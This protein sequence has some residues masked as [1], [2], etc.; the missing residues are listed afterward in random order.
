[1][2]VSVVAL[3][4]FLGGCAPAT[5]TAWPSV[6][7]VVC[8][9]TKTS[10]GAD[11]D[12]GGFALELVS[13]PSLA[14]RERL[15]R[16]QN[17]CRR[18]RPDTSRGEIDRVEC[19]DP[20][21]DVRTIVRLLRHSPARVVIEVSDHDEGIFERVKLTREIVISPKAEARLEL[22]SGCTP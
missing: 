19:V 21:A 17:G 2:V 9:I 22:R 12:D 13:E 5:A 14:K 8:G 6:D 10:A 16:L 15:L 20:H 11:V 3:A 1:M 18:Q 4:T 7:V